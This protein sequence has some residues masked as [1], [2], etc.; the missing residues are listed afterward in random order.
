MLR[1]PHYILSTLAITNI[2]Q[3]VADYFGF[4]PLQIL[5]KYANITL[6]MWELIPKI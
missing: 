1:Y 6:G 3:N 2:S 4:W 5:Y